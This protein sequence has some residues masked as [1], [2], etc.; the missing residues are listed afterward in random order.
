MTRPHAS[1]SPGDSSR[2]WRGRGAIALCAAAVAIGAAACGGSSS[3]APAA[4][5]PA[6]AV[7][8]PAA[9]GVPHFPGQLFG[10][11]KNTS[12]TAHA[13]GRVFASVFAL[14]PTKFRGAQSAVYG[15]LSGPAVVLFAASWS[16]AAAHK[17][18][19]AA[20]DRATAIGGVKGG[21]STDPQSF[22]AGPHGGSLEC[23]HVNRN[24]QSARVCVWADKMTYGGAIYILGPT[25]SLSGA[26]SKT[27]QARSMIEP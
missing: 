19:S 23:G 12:Q 15:S 16:G 2:Q 14:A 11:N 21:G 5:S 6:A 22:P 10:L 24:G 9:G 7:S 1:S 17:A 20:V 25:S 27:N 8:N 3:P 4:G 18:T 13:L 26:A